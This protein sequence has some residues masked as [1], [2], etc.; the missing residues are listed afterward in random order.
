MKTFV[1]VSRFLTLNSGTALPSIMYIHMIH[2]LYPFTTNDSRRDSD[3]EISPI[4]IFNAFK[5]HGRLCFYFA[6]SS[7]P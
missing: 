5:Q 3:V 2:S 4:W 7:V 1:F 6:L